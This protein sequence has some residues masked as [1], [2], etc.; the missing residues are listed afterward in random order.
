MSESLCDMQMVGEEVTGPPVKMDW[1]A[2]GDKE[3]FL[4]D[5]ECHKTLWD[6]SEAATGLT[7]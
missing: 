4:K 6:C 1:D 3:K 5:P 7:F 2:R